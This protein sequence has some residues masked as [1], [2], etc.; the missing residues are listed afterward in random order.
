MNNRLK[1]EQQIKNALETSFLP[2][3]K[4]LSQE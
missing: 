2:L 4:S 1:T 3:Q